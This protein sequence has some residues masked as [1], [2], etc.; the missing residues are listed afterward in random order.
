MSLIIHLK[1]RMD[2]FG[3]P[4]MTAFVDMMGR[5]FQYSILIIKINLV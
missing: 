3:L 1:I 4:P 2:F 5:D